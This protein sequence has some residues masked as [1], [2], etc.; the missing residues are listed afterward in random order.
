MTIP[1]YRPLLEQ[2]AAKCGLDADLVEAIVMQESAGRCAAYRYEPM[3]WTRYLQ[4]NPLFNTYDPQRASA[5]YGLMQVMYSTAWELGFRKT[6]EYLFIPE[7]AIE[8]GVLYLAGLMLWAGADTWKAV[9]A[10]NGGRGAWNQPQAQ[11]YAINVQS[12]FNKIKAR[13]GVAD[14]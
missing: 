13:S 5:S 7:T 11:R 9:A 14:A 12:I 10:Y 6:P 4:N 8:Y 3:F 2:E 1:W